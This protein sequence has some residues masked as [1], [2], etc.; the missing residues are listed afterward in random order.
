MRGKGKP[1]SILIFEQYVQSEKTQ[2]QYLYHLSKFAEY[3]KLKSI[4]GILPLKDLKEKIEDY[5]ILFKNNGKSVS[6]IRLILFAFQSFCEANDLDRAEI[7]GILEV[8][9]P[10]ILTTRRSC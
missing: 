2:E 1:R 5:V 9:R 7:T 6:Y 3:H 8:M 10:S 4:D